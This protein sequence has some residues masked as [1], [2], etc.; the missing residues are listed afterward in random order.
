MNTAVMNRRRRVA[1]VGWAGVLAVIV[2]SL[3]WQVAD[4]N[5]RAACLVNDKLILCAG[6]LDPWVLPASVVAGLAL[7]ITGAVSILVRRS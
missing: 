3:G 6:P 1:W 2:L 7:I 4:A 5:Q